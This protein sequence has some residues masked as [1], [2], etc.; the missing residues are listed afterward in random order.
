MVG[1]A[2]AFWN[3]LLNMQSC[4]CAP[5]ALDFFYQL[6]NQGAD[7]RQNTAF[8]LRKWEDSRRAGIELW[9]FA[10]G[11][12]C[13]EIGH[14]L[15]TY[16]NWHH[17]QPEEFGVTW[18]TQCSEKYG[19][20]Q[21]FRVPSLGLAWGTGA[22][23]CERENGSNGG[24]ESWW[25]LTWPLEVLRR[26]SHTGE[27]AQAAQA[28]WQPCRKMHVGKN[29]SSPKWVLTCAHEPAEVGKRNTTT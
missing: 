7:G 29:G 25:L 9:N 19:A 15:F 18:D 21:H 20:M 1:G 24:S 4:G 8:A 12:V 28:S 11:W 27:Y 10:A 16:G 17:D 6:P 13:A 2:K 26:H 23:E 3:Q 22:A 14:I 5:W